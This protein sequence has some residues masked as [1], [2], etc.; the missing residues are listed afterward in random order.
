[1][2]KKK[3]YKGRPVEKFTKQKKMDGIV[4]DKVSTTKYVILYIFT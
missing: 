3:T 2:S 4:I 1:M